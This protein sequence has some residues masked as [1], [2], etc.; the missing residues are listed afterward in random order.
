[1]R[2]IERRYTNILQKKSYYT[3]Y[4]AYAEGIKGQRFSRDELHRYF[5]KLVSKDD[6]FQEEKKEILRHLE[7]ITNM[8]EDGKK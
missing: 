8:L 4:I 5:N 2:S 6:Y 3:T 7:Y 1:M